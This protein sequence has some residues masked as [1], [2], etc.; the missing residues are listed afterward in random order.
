MPG[1]V[2]AAT[3]DPVSWSE[4]LS[5][6]LDGV[7]DPLDR[8]D[9]LWRDVDIEQCL[10]DSHRVGVG[11]FR[12]GVAVRPRRSITSARGP[13]AAR[14]SASDPTCTTRP[15]RIATALATG[16]IGST[17]MTW[18]LISTTSDD[19]ASPWIRLLLSGL[20]L[21]KPPFGDLISP[22]QP[23]VAQIDGVVDESNERAGGPGTAG[24][25]RVHGQAHE[26]AF[27]PD[28]I[29]V[30]PPKFVGLVR[31]EHPVDEKVV[32][33]P[34]CGGWQLYQRIARGSG[35]SGMAGRR[36][37]CPS[38]RSDR[39]PGKSDV[40]PRYT[41]NRRFCARRAAGP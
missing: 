5:R 23:D 26:R 39:V 36:A 28:N 6:A 1:L 3:N 30:V 31:R 38:P 29:E 22:R 32:V 13:A 16:L 24:N 15:A 19:I 11:S 8:T 9:A 14:A 40:C 20:I 18:P 33:V 12:P 35:R 27:G 41:A 4:P 2:V 7:T 10:P 21:R 37:E 17:V 34:L 25:E